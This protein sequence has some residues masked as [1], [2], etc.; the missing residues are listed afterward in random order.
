MISY[1]EPMTQSLEITV[2]N[3]VGLHARPATLFVKEAAKYASKVR[4]E[5]LT[6]PSP[7]VD[8]RSLLMILSIGVENGH[9]I[10]ITA[11]GDDETAAIENLK[12]LIENNFGER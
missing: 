5:N 3:K 11:N 2:R 6:N 12:T 10:R 1:E 9:T 4:V 8:A 7:L